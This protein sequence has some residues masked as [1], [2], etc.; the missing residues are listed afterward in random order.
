MKKT[1]LLIMALVVTACV[2]ALTVQSQTGRKHE[3]QPMYGSLLIDGYDH[4][5]DVGPKGTIIY[6]EEKNEFKGTYIGVKMPQGR[7]AI[8]AW[9]HDTVNQKS[10]YLGP[11]GWLKVDTGGKRK[12]KFTVKVPDKFK[13]GNFGSYEI[14]GFTSSGL[15]PCCGN[16]KNPN[17]KLLVYLRKNI[18]YKK[19]HRGC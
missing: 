2:L 19:W 11:V 6:N 3:V 1:L 12:G 13:G 9:L 10:E 5:K 4:K 14:I 18:I 16:W 17:Q 8:F 15:S 7:R